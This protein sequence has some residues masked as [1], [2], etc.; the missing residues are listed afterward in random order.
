[1][2]Y[3]SRFHFVRLPVGDALVVLLGIFLS[4]VVC[5]T[6]PTFLEETPLLF[7]VLRFLRYLLRKALAG[8][9]IRAEENREQ[10]GRYGY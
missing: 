7:G 10:E 2:R 9:K 4:F 5:A 6:F 3:R 1:M 8:A